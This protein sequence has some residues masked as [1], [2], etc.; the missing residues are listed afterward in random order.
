MRVYKKK[1]YG[2]FLVVHAVCP[3]S[4]LRIARLGTADSASRVRIRYQ[5]GRV[6]VLSLSPGSSVLQPE[7]HR[8]WTAS[9]L[10]VRLHQLGLFTTDPTG[11][12]CG[13]KIYVMRG[14]N[15]GE[16]EVYSS[17]ESLQAKTPERTIRTS[18]RQVLG[19]G[20]VVFNNSYYYIQF[21]GT[22][23]VTSLFT[24][25]D[26]STDTIDRTVP[27]P[28]GEGVGLGYQFQGIGGPDFAVSETGLYAIYSQKEAHQ[29]LAVSKINPN[30]LSI[31]STIVTTKSMSSYGECFIVCA[32]LYCTGSYRDRN[33]IT[34]FVYDLYKETEVIQRLPFR[35][36]YGYTNMLDYNPADRKLYGWDSGRLITYGVNFTSWCAKEEASSNLTRQSN[37][38]LCCFTPNFPSLTLFCFFYF[39]LLRQ[40]F[41]RQWLC[42]E[43]IRVFCISQASEALESKTLVG[44]ILLICPCKLTAFDSDSLIGSSRWS[45]SKPENISS[46]HITFVPGVSI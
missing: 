31:E 9:N 28:F 27:T 10:G 35:N 2:L 4:R 44:R 24:R 20:G 16:L 3:F 7:R 1:N 11:S 25:L 45:Y 13:Q 39:C 38:F 37:L 36:Q 5:A 6:H 19:N 8:I 32:K 34:S 21:S 18:N 46:Y 40:S 30:D 33:T 15:R 42:F 29:N 14:V 23:E 12:G 17:V 41:Q 22:P 26:L 43:K